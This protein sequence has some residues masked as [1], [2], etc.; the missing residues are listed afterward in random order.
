MSI[1]DLYDKVATT[2]NQRQSA[3]I[4]QAANQEAL[5]KVS[6]LL[7]DVNKMLSLG[8]GDGVYSKAYQRRF[9]DA[10][11]HGLDISAKMLEKAAS[12]GMKVYLGDINR[13]SELIRERDFDLVLLHFVLAYVGMRQS[14]NQ[15]HRL[16]A[17]Q[18]MVSIVSNTMGSFAK[19][20]SIYRGFL[21]AKTPWL[22]LI[23]K[24][25][26]ATMEQVHVPQDLTHLVSQVEQAG[27]VIKEAEIKKLVIH[28]PDEDSVFRFFIDGGWFISGFVHPFV[29][30]G[31]INRVTKRLIHRYVPVPYNDTAE[32]AVV[33]ASKQ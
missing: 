5:D 4:L 23:A 14:L 27:F 33:V 32:I 3:E 30:R 31:I 10:D 20:R 8:V 16:L 15:C 1:D 19:M 29:P 7:P 2:Y 6:L 26:D 22:R 9:P 21:N 25:I 13:A 18:G 17:Q 28:L 11:F 24:H 12:M